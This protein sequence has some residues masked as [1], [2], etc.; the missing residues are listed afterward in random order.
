MTVASVCV[1]VRNQ[2][3]CLGRP[4]SFYARRLQLPLNLFALRLTEK[5]L[6]NAVK[7]EFHIGLHGFFLAIA[8]LFVSLYAI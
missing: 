8:H 6:F 3:N 7:R 4:I 2:G 5:L 1:C